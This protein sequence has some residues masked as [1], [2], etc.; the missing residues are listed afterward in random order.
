MSLFEEY[1]DYL[2]DLDIASVLQ[3][4]LDE[5]DDKIFVTTGYES[6]F[7]FPLKMLTDFLEQTSSP[8]TALQVLRSVAKFNDPSLLI[9]IARQIRSGDSFLLASLVDLLEIEKILFN[10]IDNFEPSLEIV[11]VSE[12]KPPKGWTTV[13]GISV[14]SSSIRTYESKEFSLSTLINVLERKNMTPVEF[15][16]V[17]KMNSTHENGI[18]HLGEDG[19]S[20]AFEILDEIE[21]ET[22]AVSNGH[23]FN[24]NT[25]WYTG[26]MHVPATYQYTYGSSSTPQSASNAPQQQTP[27]I[28][29]SNASVGKI[30]SV[31]D[32]VLGK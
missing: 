25:T 31:I 30:K 9:W 32:S 24:G 17:L 29:V 15:A 14:T 28:N 4:E 6:N 13:S 23:Y 21:T 10:G 1:A 7:K 11:K 2:C 22:S 12:S 5:S 18:Y 20:I 8:I 26:G 3:I 16:S 27:A 19:L